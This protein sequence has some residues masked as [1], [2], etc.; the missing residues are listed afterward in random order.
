MNVE[1]YDNRDNF[2]FFSACGP[3]ALTEE[4][5]QAIFRFVFLYAS[6]PVCLPCGDPCEHVNVHP[7]QPNQP[8]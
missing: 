8:N 1:I 7:T 5:R 3:V 4:G 6:V 2:L